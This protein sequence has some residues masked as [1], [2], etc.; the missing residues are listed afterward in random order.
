MPSITLSRIAFTTLIASI[1]AVG[2]WL[3][4]A[5]I[6][7]PSTSMFIDP[8]SGSAITGETFTIR[9]QVASDIPVNVYKGDIL[10]DA[11]KLAVKQIDYN[12]SIADLWAEEPWYS[13]GEGTINF[14]GGSTRSGGFVGEDTLIT[15]IFTTKETGDAA[16]SLKEAR[17]LQH[18]GL[19]TDAPLSSPVDA[20]F[21][22]TN[23]TTM[24]SETVFGKSLLGP[25]V[26]IVPEAPSPD[27]NEDGR[28]SLAD[29]SIFMRHLAT[30]NLRSDFNLDGRVST[31]DLSILLDAF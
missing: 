1:V 6:T 2:G 21:A 29:V 16:I 15:V 22:I 10:F 24:Q 14:I 9:I 13:N 18:D 7:A 30:N 8:A 17:I 27:L 12:T 23:E 19:G 11:D 25:T 28:Q 3:M 5:T 31:A 20:I 26:R 4:G